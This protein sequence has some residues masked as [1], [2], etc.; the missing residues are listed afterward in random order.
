MV[1]AVTVI[2]RGYTASNALL[3]FIWL[4]VSATRHTHTR[5]AQK[6]L[7]SCAAGKPKIMFCFYVD[8]LCGYFLHRLVPYVW[9]LVLA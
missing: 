5:T 3:S 2:Q 1:N 9:A 4:L 6:P 7:D 8:S